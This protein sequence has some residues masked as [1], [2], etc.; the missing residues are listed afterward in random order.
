VVFGTMT[1]FKL[2]EDYRRW[3]RVDEPKPTKTTPENPVTEKPVVTP[4]LVNVPS[5][6]QIIPQVKFDMER[7][8][9]KTLLIMRDYKPNC[10]A[11]DL[12]ETYWVKPNKF[13]NR[14]EYVAVRGKWETHN[15]VKKS[16]AR[17]NAPYV[18]VDWYKVEQVAGGYKLPP[19]P[20]A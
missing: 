9:A 10:E 8:Y 17:R 14:D 19:L 2:Y 18:V 13:P 16:A 4:R 7:Q 15:I 3:Q 1:E 20:R 5:F 6:N 11:V 12:R